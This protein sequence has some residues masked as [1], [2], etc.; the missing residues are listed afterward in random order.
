MPPYICTAEEVVLRSPPLWSASRAL[1]RNSVQWPVAG[2]FD[3][4]SAGVSAL[5]S[6]VRTGLPAG[7]VGRRRTA[8]RRAAGLRRALHRAAGGAELDLASNDYLGLSQ[9]PDA[10]STAASRHFRTWG[11]GAGG[12][13]L[14]TGNTELHGVVREIFFACHCRCRIRAGVRRVHRQP[15]RWWPLSGQG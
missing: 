12:S 3:A 15:V 2:V 5:R 10:F 11:A 4:G 8:A 1:T 9:H 14:V 6:Q 7:L 13:R